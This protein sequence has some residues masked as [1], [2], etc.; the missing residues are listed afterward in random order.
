MV[1]GN[2]TKKYV[3]GIFPK[4]VVDLWTDVQVH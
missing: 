2:L 4:I 3:N 1:E